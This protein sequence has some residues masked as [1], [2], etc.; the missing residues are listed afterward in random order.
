MPIIVP[1]QLE[2]DAVVPQCLDNQFTSDRV[3]D[4]MVRDGATYDDPT[5]QQLRGEDVQTE[6]IRSLVY[7]SQVII[8]RAYLKNNNYLYKNYQPSDP[9]NLSAFAELVRQGAVL[10][11]LFRESS[12]NEDLDIDV[13][14]EG[15]RAIRTLLQE[16][17]DD[18]TCV[19]LAVDEERNHRLIKDLATKFGYGLSHVGWLDEER[20][21]VMASELFTKPGWLAEDD[22]WRA[23]ND[24]LDRLSSYA[25]K[26]KREGITRTDVY[27]DWLIEKDDKEERTKENINLG[28]FRTPGRDD[29]FVFELKK[30]VDLQYNTN[31]PDLLDRYTFTPATLPSRIALQ[32][33]PTYDADSAQLEKL[34]SDDLTD[35]L[36]YIRRTFMA[37]TQK[38]MNLPFL[39]ELTVADV[40]ELRQLPQWSAFKESQRQILREPLRTLDLIEGFQTDFDNFQRAMSEWYN[41]KYQ[42]ERTEKQYANVVQVALSIAGNVVVIGVDPTGVLPKIL[43]SAA[44]T[45]IPQTIKG[46]AVK[47]LVNVIDVGEMRLDRDRSYSLELMRTSEELTRDDIEELIR[48]ISKKGG[49][50]DEPISHLADQGKS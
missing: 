42:L 9:R 41:R 8:N 4:H 29:P 27:R 17:G 12:L 37:H 10:P 47:L 14:S 33:D 2:A 16:T 31:L 48:R 25:D 19:R 28:R 11:F 18:V 43:T 26:H 36:T 46:Y 32:D 49:T 40:A 50:P 13:R 38:A 3:F 15:N 5:V 44:T 20:R 22:R 39:S 21:N 7:S 34:L 35:A 23:F 6:F 24:M 30:L 1:H 45:L